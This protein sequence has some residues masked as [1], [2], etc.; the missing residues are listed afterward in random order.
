M[1]D[2]IVIGAGSAGC[3][4]ASRLSENPSVRVLLL[5]AGSAAIPRTMTAGGSL[6]IAVGIGRMYPITKNRNDARDEKALITAAV[7]FCPSVIRCCNCRRRQIS[8]MPE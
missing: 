6:V 5:E 1:F 7:E 3:V 8:F 4:V 2:Y